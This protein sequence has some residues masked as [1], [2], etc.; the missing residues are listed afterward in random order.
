M[1]EEMQ[2]AAELLRQDQTFKAAEVD[3]AAMRAAMTENLLPVDADIDSHDLTI[4]G[5]PARSVTAPESRQDCGILYFHG[6]GYVLGSLDTHHELM[7]R[8]SRA[9]KAP[10]LGLD[11]RLAPESPYPAAVEDATAAYLA[12]NERGISPGRIVL[13]GDSA[14]GGLVLA[15][16]LA[17]KERG[18]AMPAGAIL[19]SPWTDL[20]GSGDSV[21]TRADVDP[22]IT[23]TLLEPMAAVYRGNMAATDPGVSP[24]F[25]DL[26][27]L[28]PLLI[29]VGDHEILLDDATR[30]K[31]AAQKAG[32]TTELEVYAGAFHVF[33][34]MPQ[35]PE[36]VDAL[37]KIGTFFDRC[38]NE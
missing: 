28:P 27:D 38:L 12:L 11:Y 36:S 35:L 7:G 13:G 32:V 2:A 26:R 24:L 4:A 18:V 3:V 29:Q 9:C 21:R 20:S 23:P 22:M 10:V 8:L 30:L 19:L 31:A 37:A 15:C 33:Q 1:S 14:G 17:L 25:G 5:R 6:G 16:L 34:N